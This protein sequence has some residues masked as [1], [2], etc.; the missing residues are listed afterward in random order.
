MEEFKKELLDYMEDLKNKG[1]EPDN[2]L[3]MLE[4]KLRFE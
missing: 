3:N 2:I 4:N 1:Y